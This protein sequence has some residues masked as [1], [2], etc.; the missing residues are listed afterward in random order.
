VD[1]HHR[2]FCC[3]YRHWKLGGGAGEEGA[4]NDGACG[5]G[6]DAVGGIGEEGALNNGACGGGEDAVGG[7]GEEGALNNGARGAGEEGALNNGSD[8]G[9]NRLVGWVADELLAGGIRRIGC[10][11]PAKRQIK[12]GWC[13]LPASNEDGALTVKKRLRQPQRSWQ[14]GLQACTKT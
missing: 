3:P 10:G 13:R 14:R 4:L 6:E 8:D 7:V 12:S 11:H 5:G 9:E 1:S 2:Y